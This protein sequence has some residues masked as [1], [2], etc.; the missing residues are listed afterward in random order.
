SAACGYRTVWGYSQAIPGDTNHADVIY[1]WAVLVFSLSLGT[2]VLATCLIA[3]R[4]WR[5]GRTVA[6]TL[7]RKHG[8]NY[9]QALA[10]IIESGAIC[11]VATLIVLIAFVSGTKAVMSAAPF[12]SVFEHK[13]QE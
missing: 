10:I 2:N 1:R 6:R 5:I 3:W 4:I 9:S 11:S 13:L 8:R 7:D 12:H